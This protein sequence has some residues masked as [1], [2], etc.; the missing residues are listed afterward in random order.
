LALAGNKKLTSTG[1]TYISIYII[2]VSPHTK[3]N[4]IFY[5]IPIV[6]HLQSR[7]LKYL[8]LSSNTIDKKSASSLSEALMLATSLKTLMLD[9]C[10][11]SPAVLDILSDPIRTSV[12]LHE[13]SLRGNDFAKKSFQ[14]LCLMME[15]PLAPN[16]VL[17]CAGLVSLDLSGN[18]LRPGIRL[19]SKALMQNTQLQTLIL[20][21]CHLDGAALVPLAEALVSTGRSMSNFL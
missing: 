11:M 8:D 10:Y 15:I 21:N 9:S 20:Q 4:D 12:S 6:M 7:S 17:D 19:L 14:P 3:S 16:D 1:Y 13:V 5:I 18:D 2:K